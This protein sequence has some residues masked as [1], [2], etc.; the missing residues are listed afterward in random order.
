M[1]VL[2]YMVEKVILPDLQLQV[3]TSNSMIILSLAKLGER[4]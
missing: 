2:R 1:F 3:Y 4:Q